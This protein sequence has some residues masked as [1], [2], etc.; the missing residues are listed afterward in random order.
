[1]SK[2]SIRLHYIWF[3][4]YF[5]FHDQG[6]NLSTKYKFFYDSNKNSVNMSDNNK[7]DYID[8][9]FGSN[10]DVTA[11]VGQNGVGKTSLLR[12]ILGLRSGEPIETECVI[13]CEKGSKFWAFRFYKGN[14]QFN[15]EVL[16]IKG[17]KNIGSS[18]DMPEHMDKQIFPFADDVRLIYLTEMFNMSQYEASYSGGDDLSFAAVLNDQTEYGDEKKH[19]QNPVARYIHR[20]TDWQLDFISNGAEY[21]EQFH[22][23][24]PAYIFI[25]PSYDKDAFIKLYT[26]INNNDE[27]KTKQYRNNEY[28]KEAR[29]LSN[30]LFGSS[31]N[32]KDEYAKAIIM[33]IISSLEYNANFSDKYRIDLFDIIMQIYNLQTNIWESTYEFLM[34]IQ[35][36]NKDY[37]NSQNIRN[38]ATNNLKV[39]PINV[40]PF[41]LFMEYL[42]KIFSNNKI[43]KRYQCSLCIPTSN[44]EIIREFFNNY[45]NCVSIVDFLSF[46]WG[47]STGENLLLNQFGKLMHLLK[48]DDNGYWLSGTTNSFYSANNAVIMLDEAEVSFHPEWQ[49]K[50]FNAFLKFIKKNICERGTHVQLILATHSPIILSDIPKQN[51][52][53]LK[54]DK[55]TQNTICV[56]G[57]ETFAANIF[58]LYHNAFFLDESEIGAFAENKLCD[59]VKAI[60]SI[61]NETSIYSI[62]EEEK[63]IRQIQLI[64]DPY[65]RRKFEKEYQY[66]KDKYGSDHPDKKSLNEK[67][68]EKEKELADLKRKLYELGGE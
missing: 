25:L 23:N 64:G 52:V 6:I 57:E 28:K 11:I 54:K 43:Q 41:I 63:L 24:Y 36:H 35:I 51:T 22:I 7:D 44:M 18:S 9:F 29:E 8:D 1:M 26:T 55:L 39:F 10:I 19:T 60:H 5:G 13:V 17:I 59:L 12:F 27:S 4:D 40:N 37:Y 56:E 62:K 65:I 45:K 68:A 58:S 32:I 2:S 3:K 48:K 42:Q 16:N 53:F 46:S 20:M 31:K 33:N 38:K 50:Y 30:K 61:F 14:K 15:F 47:L 49:R 66:C 21:V 34:T 67:I